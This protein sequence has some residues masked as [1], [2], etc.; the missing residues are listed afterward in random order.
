MEKS[1]MEKHQER[2]LKFGLGISWVI[3]FSFGTQGFFGYGV[4]ILIASLA[5][6]VF[7]TIIYFLKI[8]YTVRGISI[9][10]AQ[11]ACAL[12]LAFV[13]KGTDP[14]R[15]FLV[16]MATIIMAGLFFKTK[17]I[18][19]YGI[20]ANILISIL[21]FTKPDYILGSGYLLKDFFRRMIIMDA[22]FLILFFTTKWGNELI[23]NSI[24]K[25]KE[26]RNILDKLNS[27]MENV[28]DSSKLIE[29]NTY[30][31]NDT[32]KNL[33]SSSEII[34]NEIS[35]IAKGGEII[36][37]EISEIND[38]NSC[39]DG[40]VKEI[41]Q[42]ASEVDMRSDNIYKDVQLNSEKLENMKEQMNNISNQSTLSYKSVK[43]LQSNMENIDKFLQNINEVAE[44]T[45][46]LALNAA[47]EAARAGESGRGFAV[48][49]DEIRVLAEQSTSTVK[50]IYE[51]LKR[52]KDNNEEVY[53]SVENVDNSVKDGT[54]ILD[55][56]NVIFAGIKDGYKI[57]KKLIDDESKDI[58]EIKEI[59]S[60][61][62]ESLK[63]M[64]KT[65]EE[66]SRAT[67]SVIELAEKQNLSTISISDSISSLNK[68]IGE[69]IDNY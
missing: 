13:E 68:S 7:V 15:L 2:A 12:S 52:L 24:K 26:L 14:S 49:A 37:V 62:T 53:S 60:K 11:I 3:A 27:T 33:K 58:E 20:T 17:I 39:A 19:T 22:G 36:A 10:L 64:A 23:E 55:D 40:K 21:Y 5:S 54:K 56:I 38:N 43:E 48:V 9:C 44:K 1:I 6:A 29:S 46:L 8:N 4:E 18:L 35:E 51:I 32:V 50:D 67:D 47:I 42:L 65:T 31:I 34:T 59:F 57:I 45:N 25:E 61:I 63:N 66:H 28:E 30:E 16:Y 69:L 41:K